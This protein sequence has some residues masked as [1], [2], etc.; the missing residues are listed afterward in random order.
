MPKFPKTPNPK[1]LHSKFRHFLIPFSQLGGGKNQP[2]LY[3]ERLALRKL[4]IGSKI[5]AQK[6][7]DGQ[8][9]ESKVAK[10]AVEQLEM[11]CF[12]IFRRLPSSQNDF[13]AHFQLSQNQMAQKNNFG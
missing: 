1:L 7:P 8:K 13:R 6:T 11:S 12:W 5:R 9:R 4:K 2:K 10:P 3:P